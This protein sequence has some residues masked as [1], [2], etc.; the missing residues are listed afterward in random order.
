MDRKIFLIG[1]MGT[2]KSF[3]AQKL[4]AA[5]H[6][7]FFDLDAEIERNEKRSITAI[8]QTDG[9]DEF[10]RKEAQA[11]RA[12]ANYKSFV[13]STGGGTPC[14][15]NNMQWM[16]E[17]GITIWIDESL[18]VIAERL[19]GQREHRPLVAELPEQ[20]VKDF[21][22]DMLTNRRAYY[23]Q[24]KLHLAGDEIKE[25]NFLKIIRNE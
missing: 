24:A 3:W 4:A 9:Q 10:R 13:L 18:D 25:E 15:N 2:G 19:K 5:L 20:G 17:H 11:L 14:F 22:S 1:L 8:F 7:P 16:N 6:V 21:L 23:E 12:F